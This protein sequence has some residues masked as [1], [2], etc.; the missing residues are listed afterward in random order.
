MAN[1]WKKVEELFQQARR[2]KPADR[3]AFLDGHCGGDAVLRAEVDS[4][5]AHDPGDFLEHVPHLRTVTSD[6]RPTHISGEESLPE[7]FARGRY[8]V[9]RLLGAGGQKNVYLV[10]DT[11]LG[12]AAVVSVLQSKGWDEARLA[13]IRRE[14][15]TIALLD[16]HRHIVRIFDIGDEEG[17][18]FIVTQYVEGGSVAELLDSTAGPLAIPE[19]IRIAEEI[20]EALDHAHSQGIV[21][22]D[23]KPS[24]VLLTPSRR[25]RLC[26]F[27]LA[28]SGD[29]SQLTDSGVALGTASYMSPEQA[30][31]KDVGS[32]SDLYSLG[33]LL[34]ELVT[35]IPPFRGDNA[36]AVISQHLNAVPERPSRRNPDVPDALEALLV[37][38]LEKLPSSRPP[39]ARAVLDGLRR[40][41]VGFDDRS[42][43]RV[44]AVAASSSGSTSGTTRQ[45]T[46]IDRLASGVFVGREGELATLRASL[47]SARAGH[48]KLLLIAGEPGSGKSRTVEELLTHAR[49]HDLEVLS[50]R[51][52]QEEGA[53]AFWPWVQMLRDYFGSRS[54]DELQRDLG[55]NAGAVLQ[56]DS[57]LKERFPDV[58]AAEAD[59]QWSDA[60]RVRFQ[61]FDSLSGFLRG[62][63]A[64]SPLILVIDDL[65]WAD[66]PSLRLLEFLTPDLGESSILAIAMMRD[67]TLDR[68]HPLSRAVGELSRN[69]CVETLTLSGLS[70]TDVG[71][72]IE[73]TCGEGGWDALAA[74]VWK[75]TSGNPFFVTEVVRLLAAEGRLERDATSLVIDIPPAIKAVISRRLDQL[76]PA[77]Q[78]T[79]SLAAVVGREFSLEVVE[80]L[81][82]LSSDEVFDAVEEA[83]VQR[84]LAQPSGDAERYVFTHDLIR[85]TLSQELS[86]ARRLRLHGRIGA[87]LESLVPESDTSHV[88]ELAYHFFR[89]ARAGTVAK[90]LRYCLR[91]GEWSM[92]RLAFEE[93]V[94][95]Y[96]MALQTLD[97]WARDDERTYSEAHLGAGEGQ[98]RSGDLVSAA[99]SFRA[100]AKYAK[101]SGSATALARAALGLERAIWRTGRSAVPVVGLLEESLGRLQPGALRTMCLASQA[102]ALRSTGELDR[103]GVRAQEAVDEARRLGDAATLNFT[104]F[105]QLDMWGTTN[106][107]NRLA[108]ATDLWNLARESGEID[109]AIESQAW[110]IWSLIELGEAEAAQE[111][112]D[113]KHR[114]A[115]ELGQLIHLYAA[116]GYRASWAFLTGEF[117]V[118]ERFAKEGKA[119][120]DR[121]RAENRDWTFGVQLFSIRREQG[122]LR[123]VAPAI[124]AFSQDSS[125]SAW[126]PGLALVYAE[127]GMLDEARGVFDELAANQFS[128]FTGG[129]LWMAQAAYLTDVCAYLRDAERAEILYGQLLPY[130][131]LTV[132]VGGAI[133]CYGAV[134]RYLGELASLL[135]RWDEAE[136]HFQRAAEINGRMG[137]WPW[138]ARSQAQWA[139]MLLER[140]RKDSASREENRTR[141]ETL[142]LEAKSTA[143]RL[144]MPTLVADC[145][146]LEEQLHRG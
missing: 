18:P 76:S 9:R 137:A 71:S 15:R 128:E 89:A 4:L 118:A 19:A 98:R 143:T 1:L 139:A 123:E 29:D 140:S 120:G 115:T 106:V 22:R 105:C 145:S 74:A 100:A 28:A 38:L 53:P 69:D 21:H 91:A 126:A 55:A 58:A 63:A 59:L 11:E 84:V 85:E 90:A 78:N 7:S 8:V 113:D 65:Q 116:T 2:V 104:L 42:A 12:R 35:G 107:E 60:E 138:L 14:A 79:L 99:E 54:D 34:Y 125:S 49:L 93:S 101:S 48:G 117:D 40:V 82:E 20:C 26:D 136:E 44:L 36:L 56:L 47:E 77:C 103:A 141:A 133:V 41:R 112:I 75:T 135:E 10:D 23:V 124:R 30:M 129:E 114:M 119:I 94:R 64:T 45:R 102:R 16:D 70:K 32:A 134:G 96:D 95:Y 50:G 52:S 108:L 25:V 51:C 67:V 17:L 13:R 144:A 122:R 109:K 111:A 127:L 121:I 73:T 33:I 39:S 3:S 97:R 92:Q 86:P 6:G 61:L 87:I 72:F 142:I 43:P 57:K 146:E 37:R 24:N 130:A 88:A 46:A 110:R 66:E 131:D 68:S 5:L 31:G 132:I 80:R 62:V 83:I 81:S 27:G